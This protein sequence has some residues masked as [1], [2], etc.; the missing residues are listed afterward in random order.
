MI[1]KPDPDDYEE[2]AAP[3]HWPFGQKLLVGIAIFCLFALVVMEP[4]FYVV[5]IEQ[6][7]AIG[8]SNHSLQATNAKTLNAQIPG[9]QAQIKRDDKTISDDNY[10]LN[11]EAVPA[12]EKLAKQ[13]I[14]LHGNPGQIELKPPSDP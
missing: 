1:V 9:L 3:G 2:I 5:Q 13:V 4:F 6:L 10:I 14:A 7:H 8:N 11:Q 12:I